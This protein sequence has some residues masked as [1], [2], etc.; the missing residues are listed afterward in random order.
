MVML[1]QHFLDLSA[2]V[3]DE[4]VYSWKNIRLLSENDQ[5]EKKRNEQI[6]SSFT[7]AYSAIQLW[8]WLHLVSELRQQSYMY[9]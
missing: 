2:D 5:S 7:H 1:S 4:Q 6:N 8:T 9:T 3:I